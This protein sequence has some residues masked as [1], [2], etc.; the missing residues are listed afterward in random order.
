M[1]N[2]DLYKEDH[3]GAHV[4]IAAIKPERL[5]QDALALEL[6]EEA[7][8]LSAL[9]ANFKAKAKGDVAALRQLLAE[10]YDAKLGGAK[11]NV[12]IRSFDGK[13]EVQVAVGESISFGPEL[14]VAKDLIDECVH[15]WS[16]GASDNIKALVDHAFQ[17][18]KEGRIDT[19]RVLG[20]RKLAIDDERWVRAMDAIADS[21]EVTGSKTYVR[22]YRRDPVTEEKTPISLD[23]AR[24]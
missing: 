22:V 9:L 14:Q 12:T 17:V 1:T 21:V 13:I 18:N 19:G 4:P 10:K 8:H 6:A 24:V 2:D 7:E 20:L 3:R 16:E 23:L 11:G 15:A 5:L